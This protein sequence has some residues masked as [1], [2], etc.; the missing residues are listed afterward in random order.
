VINENDPVAVEELTVGDNDRLSALVAV[1]LGAERL[2][3]LT[4]IDGVYDADPR[5]NPQA[6]RLAE[7]PAITA[8]V[9]AAAGGAGARGRGGMRSKIEAARLACAAGV[10]TH[11]C[12]AREPGVIDRVFAGEA[13][14]TRIQGRSQRADARRRWLAVGRRC[15]GVIHVDAGAATALV[16]KGRS[17]L[18]AGVQ[19]V[20]GRFERGDTV[21]ISDPAGTE[22]ARGLAGLSSDELAAVA[23]KRLDAATA[24][25]GYALPKAA[26]HRDN[27]LVLVR[28]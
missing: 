23:G 18:P 7:I 22:V 20:E 4:D 28:G 12:H 10:T 15:K 17:L 21:A 13:V 11:I 25:L 24:A 2:V 27:L 1:Q 5:S 26:V 6:R 19:R 14:G 9:L 3:L 8:A 16:A